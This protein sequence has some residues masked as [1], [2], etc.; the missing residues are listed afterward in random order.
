MPGKAIPQISWLELLSFDKLVHAAIFFVEQVLLMRAIQSRVKGFAWYALIFA[1]IYGGSLELMQYYV[2]SERS[3]DVFD[4]IA[5]T[6][7]ALVGL[8]LFN[9]LNKRLSFLPA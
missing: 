6:T 2:F 4:F 9:K 3:G 1:V 5:N 8:L 7:G